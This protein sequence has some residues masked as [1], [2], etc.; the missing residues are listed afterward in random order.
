[1]YKLLAFIK[2]Y[3]RFLFA[4][5]FLIIITAI[6]LLL[7]YRLINP[8]VNIIAEFVEL[9]PLYKRMPVYFR[10]YKIG[11]TSKIRPSKDYKTT[12]VTIVFYPDD[13]KLPENIYAKVKKLTNGVDYISLEYPEKPS[14]QK[15]KTGSVIH[16]S[17]SLDIQSFMNAQAEGGTLG[18]IT[19]NIDSTLA[20][21]TKVGKDTQKLIQTLTA[22]VNENRN[23]IKNS[24][25][26]FNIATKNLSQMSENLNKA[27]SLEKMEN[28]TSN[29]EDITNNINKMTQNLEQATENLDLT[30]NR[31]DSILCEIDGTAKNLNAVTL[32]IRKTLNKNMGALKLFLGKPVSNKCQNN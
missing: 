10:G 29:L 2:N 7:V 11:N 13:L 21:F 30:M 25:N 22:T 6:I 20:E 9:G 15:L 27:I 17:T 23:S 14:L 12:L 4:F 16:G 1:M 8:P 18:S 19:S 5:L 31:V 28:S 26:N 3:S 32:G 24:V